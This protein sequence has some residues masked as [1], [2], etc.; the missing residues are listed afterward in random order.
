[1]LPETLSPVD[2]LAYGSAPSGDGLC[3]EALEFS[4]LEGRPLWLKFWQIF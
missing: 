1:M 3:M 2:A 4:R